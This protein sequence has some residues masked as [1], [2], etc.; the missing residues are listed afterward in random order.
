MCSSSVVSDYYQ[1][2]WPQSFPSTPDVIEIADEETK[3]ML[4]RALKLLDKVDKRLND[5]E[6]K[7]E[8]K[9]AFLAAL[10]KKGK[11]KSRSSARAS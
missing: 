9:A 7:D 10:A 3:S 11:G 5:I 4:R 6:C 2:Q 8:Q 1:S